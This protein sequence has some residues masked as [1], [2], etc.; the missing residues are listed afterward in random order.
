MNNKNYPVFT[1]EQLKI[2]DGLPS[3]VLINVLN[4]EGRMEYA[5]SNPL[6]A[7]SVGYEHE[8][9]QQILRK[10]VFALIYE[11][12]RKK[13]V[14]ARDKVM[15]GEVVDSITRQVRKDGSFVWILAHLRK[16]EVDGHIGI[17][18]L[19]SRIQE[20][21]GLQDELTQQNAAWNDIIESIPIGVC[22]FRE[23]NG[24]R[25][26]LA[27]NQNLVNV[28]NF[29]GKQI[30]NKQRAWTEAELMMLLNKDIFVF[31]ETE[32]IP[33]IQKMLEECEDNPL[34]K[35]IFRLHGSDMGNVVYIYATCSLKKAD[36]GSKTYYLTFQNV[37]KEEN[38]RHE[39]FEKQ[40]QLIE[41]SYYDSLTG[42]KNRNAYN[43]FVEHCRTNHMQN[44]GFAFCDLNGLKTINDSVG[45][46]YGDQMI[47]RFTGIIKEYFDNDSI[48]RISGD[49]FVIV[50]PDTDRFAFRKRMGE[51]I[52]RMQSE[53]NIASIGFV[54]KEEVSDIPRRTQQAE[55]L[56]YLEK[57]RY[58]EVSRNIS[59]KH[60]PQML[61]ALLQSFEDGCF[62]MY[63]QPKTSI[64]GTKIIGA[65]ALARKTDSNGNIIPPL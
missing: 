56:M 17:L 51:V 13:T 34:A 30:D 22:V 2:F 36:D 23:C 62:V 33:I 28:A 40:A 57:Q 63:L 27:V 42:V 6:L 65:E 55:Q 54:W 47:K 10:E 48:F 8:E 21:I 19:F 3:P 24:I 50:C 44:V 5:Y 49:E 35:S 52:D 7:H 12:D 58:Y 38:D 41:L 4:D 1:R 31:C 11:A 14:A 20:L 46:Y 16:V 37:T 60:R 9:L 26:L 18:F 15:S 45:H 61:E 64:D 39:L 53:D 59:S 25:T 32:D 43:E 29:A